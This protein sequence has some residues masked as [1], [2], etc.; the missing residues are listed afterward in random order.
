M[1]QSP[2]LQAAIDDALACLRAEWRRPSLDL[3]SGPWTLA[4]AIEPVDEFPLLEVPF[5]RP[6]WDASWPLPPLPLPG[7]MPR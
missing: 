2:D 4:E 7:L 1:P 6:S 5:P 3:T